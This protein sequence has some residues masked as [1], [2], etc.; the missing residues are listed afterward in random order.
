MSAPTEIPTADLTDTLSILS[1]LSVPMAKPAVKVKWAVIR[2][3]PDLASGELLNVG[4]AVL[5]RRKVHVRL[6]PNAAPFEALYG[7]NGRENFSFLLN[8]IGKHL[9]SRN[10]L[11][12]RISPQVKIGKP[13]FAA[14]DNVKE[15][16]D[17]I[18]ASMVPLDLMCRKKSEDQRRN[19]STERLRHKVFM[20][21]READTKFTD[22]VWHDEKNPIIIP[23]DSGRTAALPH[24]Q[25]WTE[26]DIAGG[27]IRFASFVSTDYQ[28][29]MP[30]D[31]HLLLAKQ[32][33]ELASNS[34]NKEEKGAGLFVYRPDDMPAEI[35][36]NIDNTIDHTHWL[37]SRNIKD[38]SLFTM[39]VE[40]DISKL[41]QAARA[42]ILA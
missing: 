4:I 18:Y 30:A 34:R 28:K 13:Q 23:T 10:D 15:I 35:S 12:A 17:R 42:F 19:I 16:L 27:P 25:L 9:Q 32:D 22:R 41:I 36:S 31:L 38:K 1:G 11:S 21:F 29:S 33:I 8:L 5:Y 14:G 37:L 39:E 6:L 26:P 3:M 7:S 2:I 24:L 40:S 20:S